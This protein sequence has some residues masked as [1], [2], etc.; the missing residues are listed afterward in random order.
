MDTQA[1]DTVKKCEEII[2]KDGKMIKGDG[3]T[4]LEE[5]MKLLDPDKKKCT[6]S[7]M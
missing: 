3:L 6:I 4:V 7:R 2:F 5:K 1:Y